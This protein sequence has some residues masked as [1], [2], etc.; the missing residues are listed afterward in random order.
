MP[1]CSPAQ[2]VTAAAASV[3]MAGH[4]SQTEQGQ[5]H[6]RPCS[7]SAPAAVGEQHSGSWGCI[8]AGRTLLQLPP[9]PHCTLSP[10][11]RDT[12]NVKG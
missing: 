9:N 5:A 3:V 12:G 8:T 1:P 2:S 4:I 10:C 11:V 6:N 7:A